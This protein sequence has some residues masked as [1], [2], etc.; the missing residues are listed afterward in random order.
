MISDPSDTAATR[1]LRERVVVLGAGGQLGA[2]LVQTAPS[3]FDCVAFTR[4]QC[5][6]TDG[7]MLSR[8]MADLKP[9][10][11]VNAAAFTA[12]DLAETKRADAIATNAT[13]PT[14]L[15]RLARRN[16]FRVLHVSTDYVFDGISSRPYQPSDEPNPLSVYG[17]SKRDG[18][19][20]L[21]GEAGDQAIVV[22][23]SWLY[24]H[25]KS[26]FVLRILERLKGS[27]PVTVVTDHVG[28]PT[29]VY[30]L[31]R[32]LWLIARSPQLVGIQHFS[33]AGVASWYEFAQAIRQIGIEKGI[34]PENA[35]RIDPITLAELRAPARRPHFSVLDSS[36]LREALNILARPWQD[37]LKETLERLAAR[38]TS[39]AT[40]PLT[41]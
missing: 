41:R 22:R 15:G 17:E 24:S 6:I 39:R 12:V 14:D 35:P 11:V 37:V 8:V 29:S 9:A 19:L 34:V 5:D 28:T 36:Q 7:V 38:E 13:A 4:S 32:V 16:G 3:D 33:D 40:A 10:T 26:N 30:S 25:E 18:E 1:S 27:A 21:L 23:T 20:G 2:A 31:A